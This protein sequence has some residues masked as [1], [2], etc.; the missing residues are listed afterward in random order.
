MDPSSDTVW[1]SCVISNKR[2]TTTIIPIAGLS[3]DSKGAVLFQRTVLFRRAVPFELEYSSAGNKVFIPTKDLI[4]GADQSCS[5]SHVILDRPYLWMICTPLKCS[6]SQEP[7]EEDSKL[8]I[9]LE[10]CG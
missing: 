6:I 5:T 8:Y 3:L 1:P 4:L 9:C 2:D 7:L 10:R